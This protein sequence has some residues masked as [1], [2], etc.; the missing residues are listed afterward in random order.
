MT[1]QSQ[2]PTLTTGGLLEDLKNGLTREDIAE[3][4]GL[5]KA[6]VKRVFQH[7]KLKNKKTI[8][9]KEDNFILID[10]IEDEPVSEQTDTEQQGESEQEAAQEQ[11]P[12][13]QIEEDD[14]VF[15][16]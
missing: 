5:T 2:K 11:A 1:E 4:Y 3:K 10:D 12:E 6:D 7:P 16:S 14:N 13:S 8:K 9:P 15:R